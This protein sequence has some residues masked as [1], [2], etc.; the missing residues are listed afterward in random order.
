MTTKRA[1]YAYASRFSTQTNN[2]DYFQ[3]HTHSENRR[4]THTS[5]PFNKRENEGG[6][7]RK[8]NPKDYDERELRRTIQRPNL[9]PEVLNTRP[10]CAGIIISRF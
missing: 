3:Q 9:F 7:E 4:A 10:A 1:P 2:G 6:V 5:R 8:R